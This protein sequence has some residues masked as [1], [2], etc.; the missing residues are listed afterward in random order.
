MPIAKRTRG[1]ITL[2][3]TVGPGCELFGS[4]EMNLGDLVSTDTL[5]RVIMM[6]LLWQI[7]RRLL[8]GIRIMNLREHNRQGAL[9]DRR[10]EGVSVR[11][12]VTAMCSWGRP[13]VERVLLNQIVASE[14]CD[15]RG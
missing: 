4:R 12:H 8:G 5:P 6:R 13:F 1:D 7:M 3:Y 11:R 14:A 2:H 9:S 10:S 15:R